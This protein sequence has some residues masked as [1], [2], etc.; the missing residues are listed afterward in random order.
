M[1]VGA[2]PLSYKEKVASL[3]YE[4]RGDFRKAEKA[5][6]WTP[7]VRLQQLIEMMVK[8]DIERIKAG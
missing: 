5:L 3:V 1:Y 4:L 8:A 7:R 6:G 2:L